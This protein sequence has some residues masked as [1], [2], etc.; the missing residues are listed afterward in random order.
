MIC[1][2]LFALLPASSAQEW[3]LGVVYTGIIF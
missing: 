1:M 3:E 2:V